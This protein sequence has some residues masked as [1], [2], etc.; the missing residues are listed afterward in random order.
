M[1]PRQRQVLRTIAM[2]LLVHLAILVLVVGTVN[3][4]G[5][6]WGQSFPTTTPVTRFRKVQLFRAWHEK[7]PVQGLIMGSSRSMKLEPQVFTEG[8]GLRYFNFSVSAGV[9]EDVDAILGFVEE[10]HAAPR[11]IILGIDPPMLTT[12]VLPNELTSDW[13]LAPRVERRQPTLGWKIEHGAQLMRDAFTPG[14]AREV[15]TSIVAAINHKQPLHYFHEDG[16]LEYRGWDRS[17]AAGRYDRAGA[18]RRCVSAFVDSLKSMHTFDRH[19]IALLDSVLDRA[20]AKGIHVTLWLTPHH[21][22]FYTTVARYPVLNAYLLALPDT[23]QRVATTHGVPFVNLRT[24]DRF[25]G[26]PNDYYDCTHVGPKNAT[27]IARMLTAATQAPPAVATQAVVDT[28][29]RRPRRVSPAGPA[30][31]Q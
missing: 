5:G 27:L 13:E 26:D 23:L 17:I 9:L 29:L 25:G 15:G 21:P 19:R 7:A 18:V 30:R 1:N 10:R 16:Y 22:D 24:I 14:Y 2:T 12:Y 28:A 6:L 4:L 8:T 3:P 11:E 31:A 20:R